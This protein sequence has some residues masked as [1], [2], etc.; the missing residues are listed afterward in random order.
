METIERTVSQ[1]AD[2]LPWWMSQEWPGDE[3]PEFVEIDGSQEWHLDG[4]LHRVDGPAAIRPDGSEFWYLYGRLHRADGPAVVWANGDQTWYLHGKRHRTDGPAVILH[5]GVQAWYQHGKRR[6][7]CARAC[8]VDV[9]C[10][11]DSPLSTEA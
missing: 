7:P 2:A 9:A 4:Q 6:T 3:E 5:S 8:A 10:V 1:P 11:Q